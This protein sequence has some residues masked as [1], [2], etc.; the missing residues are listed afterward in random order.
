MVS[1]VGW[2]RRGTECYF[3]YSYLQCCIHFNVLFT[4][5]SHGSNL[6][7]HQ[8]MTFEWMTHEWIKKMWNTHTHTHWN[9]T[10]S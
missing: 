3:K 5:A 8:H 7:V 1:F 2:Q 6:N 10:E 9:I 4:I